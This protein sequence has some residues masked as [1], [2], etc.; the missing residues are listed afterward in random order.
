M[1]WKSLKQEKREAKRAAWEKELAEREVEQRRR[2]S[3]TLCETIDEDV[4]DEGLKSI[5][6]RLAQGERNDTF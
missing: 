1:V 6:H 5:L 2:D 4:Q 3:R